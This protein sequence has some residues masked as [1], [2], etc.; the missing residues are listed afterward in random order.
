LTQRRC[1]PLHAALATT[2][3]VLAWRMSISSQ[4]GAA[5]S[6][7]VALGALNEPATAGEGSRDV[8]RKPEGQ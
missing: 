5:V 7:N 8:G 1:E 6:R 3:I 4:A 2:L